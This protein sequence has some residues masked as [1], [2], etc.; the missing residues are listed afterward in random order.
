MTGPEVSVVVP[1]LDPDPRFFREAIDSVLGQTTADWE[2]VLVDDGSGDAARATAESFAAA[3]RRIRIVAAPEPRPSGISAARNAGIASARGEFVAM[4]DADD[5]YEPERLERHVAALRATPEA[6][7]AYGDTLYWTSWRPGARPRD[8]VP[9]S[10][11]RA[12][13]LR[14][15]RLLV[16]IMEGRGASPCT[17][18]YTIRRDIL[19]QLRGFE[20]D[21]RS[22]YE[23]QVFL[24]KVSSAHPV[25]YLGTALDR[26][27]LHPD[28]LTAGAS[29]SGGPEHRRRF[30]EWVEKGVVPRTSGA[31]RRDIERAI[32]RARW[33]IRHPVLAD[34]HRR[35]RKLARRLTPS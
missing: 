3:D 20:P 21:F 11:F 34:L 32:G 33:Q 16:S 31:V 7:M 10:G 9:P 12:G 26:Y 27:R 30:I 23:D 22:M 25:L 15:P 28:S 2:L 1:F 8:K 24:S 13:L 29:N 18:S 6:A 14:P 17:C 5:C 35:L 19:E 4:L